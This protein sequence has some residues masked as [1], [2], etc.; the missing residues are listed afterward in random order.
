MPGEDAAE[1]QAAFQDTR[2]LWSVSEHSR[3]LAA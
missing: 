2:L 1:L 3:C